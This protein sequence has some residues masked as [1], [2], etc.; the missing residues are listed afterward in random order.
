MS[1]PSR[2]TTAGR[3][4]LDLRAQARRE[5]RPTDELLVLYVLERFLFRLSRSEHRGRLVLKG[6][7]LLAAFDERRP[8]ADVDLLA[9]QVSNDADTIAA[10]VRDVLAVEVDDGVVFEPDGLR[11]QVIRDA[12]PY[13]GVRITVPARIA[14]ARHPLRVDVNVGDPVTPAPVE[15]E[16]PALLAEPFGVVGYPLATVLA[17]KIVTMVDRGDATTRER[18]FADVVVLTKRHAL[19]AVDFAAAVRATGAHRQSDLRPLRSVLV[20]LAS[21]RQGDWERFV[22]RSGLADEVPASFADTIA[23]VVDFADPI[24]TGD[25]T[26]GEWDAVTRAWR[27]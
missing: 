16:Y 27:T 6:G 22:N 10:L 18:D 23:A 13:T 5:D 7:M 14:R 17:E 25:V 9:R 8:T 2:D 20:G 3:V 26:S 15:V 12:E 21:A 1:R 24:L 11:A 19:D 4:Y